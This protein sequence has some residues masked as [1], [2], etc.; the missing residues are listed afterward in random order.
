MIDFLLGISIGI[1]IP[2]VLIEIYL[3]LYKRKLVVEEIVDD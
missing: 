3:H 1:F 2:F